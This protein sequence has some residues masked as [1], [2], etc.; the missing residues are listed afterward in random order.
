VDGAPTLADAQAFLVDLVGALKQTLADAGK[1]R[2]FAGNVLATNT[3]EKQDELKG[4]LQKSI[5]IRE[6]YNLRNFLDFDPK[7]TAPQAP[8]RYGRLDAVDSIVNEAF[9]ATVEDQDLNNPT[10]VARHGDALVSYPFLWDTA[11][12]D[13]VEWLG[14][15]TNG[16]VGDSLVGL[17]GEFNGLPRNVGEVLGVFGDFEISDPPSALGG[18]YHSSVRISKLKELE[19]L[20]RTLWSPEWPAAFPKIDGAAALAGEELYR[21]RSGENIKDSCLDCHAVIDRKTLDR[22]RIS[23]VANL[24]KTNTDPQA[25]INF[26]VPTR[27][28]GKLDGAFA[29]LVG[30]PKIQANTVAE[31]VLSNVVVGVILGDWKSAPPDKLK[32]IEFGRRGAFLAAEGNNSVYKGR[33]LDGIWATAPYLHNGSVPTLDD[34]LKPAAER[35]KS[36]SVGTRFFDPVKVG[37]QADA[38]GF[39]R[40]EVLD[41]DG[42]AIVGHSNG[43][44]EFGGALSPQERR[45]LL[46]YLKTL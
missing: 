16:K 17:V 2:R 42:K 20:V 23:I 6:G 21:K 9:W 12:H 13:K 36:F 39:P 29:N 38:K 5:K 15:A 3:Q 1:F 14:I 31:P 44:H 30:G 45:Q 37:F 41:K 10:V 11:Q 35:P 24:S 43:G 7:V 27:P 8:A 19:D 46:E 40:F 33:P 32:E 22:A 18:G 28:S 4:E 25:F 34:L 26:F